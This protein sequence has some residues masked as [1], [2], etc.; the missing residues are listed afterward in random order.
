MITRVQTPPAE[1]GSIWDT[2]GIEA[3]SFVAPTAGNA[4]VAVWIFVAAGRT[5]SSVV[6]DA[7]NTYNVL[8]SE[9]VALDG[10]TI[11]TAIYYSRVTNPAET[12]TVTLSSG[13]GAPGR[14]A[15]REYSDI[16]E[17]P[18]GTTNTNTNASGTT[19]TTG[20]VTTDQINTLMLAAMANIDTTTWTP[21]GDFGGTILDDGHVIWADDIDAGVGTHAMDVGSSG[22]LDTVGIIGWLKGNVAAVEGLEWKQPTSQPSNHYRP[23][24]LPL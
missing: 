23:T 21:D 15:I 24:I 11:R 16:I 8:R 2:D 14:L 20:T 7:G 19:H 12:I 3:I 13:T 6:D 1:S 4:L 22:N 18:L 10:G 5:I 17:S 9:Q